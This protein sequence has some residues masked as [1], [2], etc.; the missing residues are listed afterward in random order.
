MDE[1]IDKFEKQWK[2]LQSTCQSLEEGNQ[3]Y[4]VHYFMRHNAV[5]SQQF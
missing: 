4:K 1:E 5:N 3:M 2:E